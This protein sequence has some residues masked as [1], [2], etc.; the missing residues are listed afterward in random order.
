MIISLF[1][2]RPANI[3]FTAHSEAENAVTTDLQPD[4]Q[5]ATETNDL[6]KE[7]I[8]SINLA[9][10]P[11]EDDMGIARSAGRQS[12][13]FDDEIKH[14]IE[15]VSNIEDDS[16]AAAIEQSPSEAPQAQER[17]AA[18]VGD[19][20]KYEDT[21]ESVA[22]TSKSKRKIDDFGDVLTGAKKM[23]YGHS[24]NQILLKSEFLDA[25]S[26][27]LARIWPEPD[28]KQLIADGV[29]IESVS[30]IRAMR[31][32]AGSKRKPRKHWQA[33]SYVKCILLMRSFAKQLLN[34]E[35]SRD[36]LIAEFPPSNPDKSGDTFWSSDDLP[37]RYFFGIDHNAADVRTLMLAYDV[38]SHEDSLS[39]HKF[40]FSRYAIRSSDYNDRTYQN[41]WG[42]SDTPFEHEVV[43]GKTPNFEKASYYSEAKTRLFDSPDEMISFLKERT[44]L[45]K[46]ILK[47]RELAEQMAKVASALNV[48]T[49]PVEAAELVATA[50]AKAEASVKPRKFD[51]FKVY[52]K[53][54]YGCVY[55]A[56][57][58]GGVSV[59]LKEMP[60]ATVNSEF[61]DWFRL[62][63]T[64]NEL[65]DALEA[66]KEVPEERGT[67]N[68][69][70]LGKVWR[71]GGNKNITPDMFEK[72]F[73][74]R[75]VQFGNWVGD[76]K[77]QDDLN[78]AYDAL[79]DLSDV[80]GVPPRAISLAGTLG[81]AFGARGNG[82][83]NPAAAHYEPSS[84]VI[85]LTKKNGAG[86]LAHEWWHA[87]DHHM[88]I[89]N[90]TSIGYITEATRLFYSS[91]TKLRTELVATI[92]EVANLYGSGMAV[93]NNMRSRSQKIDSRKGGTPYWNTQRE[94]MA[95][96]FEGYVK[97]K[98]EIAGYSNDYLANILDEDTYSRKDEYPY[99]NSTEIAQVLEKFDALSGAIKTE[100][101]DENIVMF[102]FSREKIE[103][104]IDALDGN[105]SK[106]Q[107]VDNLLESMPENE[108]EIQAMLCRGER[109]LR[110]GLVPLD[111]QEMHDIRKTYFD[112]A[113][114]ELIMSDQR[115][116]RL[117]LS[118]GFYDQNSGLTFLNA[119]NI[120]S[121]DAA[122]VFLHEISHG[123]NKEDVNQQA[124]H[125]IGSRELGGH[126]AHVKAMLD[127]VAKRMTYAGVQL[128]ASEATA[129]LVETACLTGR[130]AGHSA[131][132]GKFLGWLSNKLGAK[133]GNWFRD[134]VAHIRIDAMKCGI[135]IKMTVDDFVA[136]AKDGVYL[137]SQGYVCA[138][139]SLIT[140]QKND[141][142][143]QNIVYQSMK[144]FK[145]NH[146]TSHISLEQI[147]NAFNSFGKVKADD[148]VVHQFRAV[149]IMV[150]GKEGY[151][152]NVKA[153]K[154]ELPYIRW[155]QIRTPSFKEQVDFSMEIN[156]KT[157]EP[158]FKHEKP[159]FDSYATPSKIK[160]AWIKVKSSEMT[161]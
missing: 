35:K 151:L 53:R 54:S 20:S 102:S 152:R 21:P 82:G 46:T 17:E 124:L 138:G 132:D 19:N 134:V 123:Q 94:L 60:D 71:T 9:V 158:L 92:K 42:I 113:G 156:F 154:T 10:T 135:K 137:A 142:I 68:R 117:Q 77:R 95:R 47:Q 44:D 52:A 34:G 112:I 4:V 45:Y 30:A 36:D 72:Q 27:P 31:D 18:P 33:E 131:I 101:K 40:T 83:R 93:N 143:A 58:Y 28:Y 159:D 108:Q 2:K 149:E 38:L 81:L 115:V 7:D 55:I 12:L 114:S 1:E 5:N 41:K 140:P 144:E 98:L 145:V 90:G 15:S 96:T 67:E 32:L 61:W 74:F 121:V 85:N 97:K 65:Q 49:I 80:M 157:G 103:S 133:V 63:S 104:P 57:R 78:K 11:D 127:D 106:K 119:V 109:G 62:E 148:D 150:G 43:W 70:R 79:M 24:Y 161:M 6:K 56:V 91:D 29:D 105:T 99:P 120:E 69:E 59:T 160:T 125:L 87:F 100:I 37:V 116:E 136:Y 26:M 25:K 89:M 88:S 64:K 22:E 23:S 3:I 51:K 16:P 8:K 13:D 76:K 73:G 84:L 155:I 50:D 122:S 153:G 130:Q 48:Q 107:L 129:Y 118:Q 126:P 147:K 39:K 14:E 75:G 66:Y 146:D 128:N 86:S 110:G 111:L 141:M 139:P